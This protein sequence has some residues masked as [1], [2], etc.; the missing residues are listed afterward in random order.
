MQQKTG[1]FKT[2]HVIVYP[3]RLV[4]NLDCNKFQ[5]ISCY[6][7]SIIRKI[8]HIWSRDFKTSHV[9]V[10]L[11]SSRLV[12][13]SITISKHLMLL[14]IFLISLINLVFPNF[15]TSHV[16]VYLYLLNT[17]HFLELHF[18]TSHVI[19]YPVI[20]LAGFGS[21]VFQNISCYCLSK[22]RS[23]RGGVIWISKHL[24]LLFIFVVSVLICPTLY[25]KTS[26]VIVY[27]RS[28]LDLKNPKAFQNISCYCLSP[29]LLL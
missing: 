8:L 13:N 16:I 25:F 23:K 17:K 28:P 24:M 18:K 22:S 12:P 2:S 15:K 29:L 4:G 11:I 10:Y 21:V 5:N 26:H 3:H 7:L 19:V 27:L 1:Y 6:C 20:T 9:I 14:F